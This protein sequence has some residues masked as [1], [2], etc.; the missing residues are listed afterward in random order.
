LTRVLDVNGDQK[1][2][3]V[4]YHDYT[5]DRAIDFQLNQG[6]NLFGPQ[7][8]IDADFYDVT[9]M[10]LADLNGDQRPDLVAGG[11]ESSLGLRVYKNTGT[12][13]SESQRIA[14]FDTD[15]L[16]LA[17]VD[18]DGDADVVYT[19]QIG[20]TYAVKWR[21][22]NG[23]GTFGAEQAVSSGI[24]TRSIKVVDVD[25]DG[26]LDVIAHQYLANTIAW[27][28]NN[29][30]GVFGTARSIEGNLGS[31]IASDTADADNDGDIDLVVMAGSQGYLYRNNGS[32]TFTRSS[33]LSSIGSLETIKFVRADTDAFPDLVY[34]ANSSLAYRR[35]QGNGTFGSEQFFTKPDTSWNTKEFFV[36]DYD[37]DGREDFVSTEWGQDAVWFHRNST[38]SPPNIVSFAATDNTVNA[39]ANATLT[40]SVEGATSIR[41]DGNVVTGTSLVVTPGQYDKTYTLTATNA[42][43]TSTAKATVFVPDTVFTDQVTLFTPEFSR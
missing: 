28:P 27:Y 18:K 40:W 13:F 29:G 23:S 7:V 10:E 30:S 35:N 9:T 11:G 22:N 36:T 25:K 19:H 16:V 38:G 4:F 33:V 3:L 42:G 1:P 20:S 5:T 32:G 15:S 21:P 39:G 8:S 31:Q 17:D 43:G 41:I 26:D 14:G 2:D 24:Y 37:K 12:G 34:E 6:N